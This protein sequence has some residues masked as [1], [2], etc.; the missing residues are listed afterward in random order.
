MQAICKGLDL[1]GSASF[2]LSFFDYDWTCDSETLRAPLQGDVES[3]ELGVLDVL[4]VIN[5]S[6][7]QMGLHWV[8]IRGDGR[9]LP[10]A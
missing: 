2:A 4:R 8:H 1:V 5:A 10:P 7:V 3:N 9:C 6:R